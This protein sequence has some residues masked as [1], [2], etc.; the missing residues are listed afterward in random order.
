MIVATIRLFN[1]PPGLYY[2]RAAYRA[3]DMPE[4]RVG[5]SP[6]LLSGRDD[7]AGSLQNPGECRT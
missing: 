2:L 7:A 4:D 3:F 1:I 5:F 6:N